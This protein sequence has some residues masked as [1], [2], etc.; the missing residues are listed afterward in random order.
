MKRD[1]KKDKFLLEE[2]TW[3]EAG[4]KFKSTD[5]VILPV[6]STEQH[7]LHLPVSTD[8]FDAYW[9]SIEVT[10]KVKSPKPIV[11]PPINYGVSYHHLAFPGTISISPDTLSAIVYEIGCSLA[12]YG[13]KKILI[14][15]GHGGNKAAIVCAAQKLNYEKDLRIFIDSGEITSKEVNEIIK[16]PDDTHSGEYET[17]TSLANREHLVHKDK[18]KKTKLNFPSSYLR[19]DDKHYV[20]WVFKTEEIS[21]TGAIGDPTKAS[22]EKGKKIWA[23]RIEHLVKFIEQVKG[24]K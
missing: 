3:E 1:K 22:K 13:V 7:S 11:L 2:M 15:N 23:V 5:M 19:F 24:L 16:T 21:V 4:Q 9:L 17:S 10:E 20:P 8:S 18:I 14:I 12:G 6:G